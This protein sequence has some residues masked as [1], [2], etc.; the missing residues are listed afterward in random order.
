MRRLR[1]YPPCVVVDTP[2]TCHHGH[3]QLPIAPT[4]RTS[5]HHSPYTHPHSSSHP[6]YTPRSSRSTITYPCLRLPAA[7]QVIAAH[8]R[9][10]TLQLPALA[11]PPS[12][13]AAALLR[14]HAHASVT[15]STS[16][17]P[18]SAR[19]HRRASAADRDCSRRA[20]VTALLLSAR[21]RHQVLAIECACPAG[22]DRAI[23]WA[24]AR[25]PAATRRRGR[26][27][28][29]M[30]KQMCLSVSKPGR[31]WQGA[32]APGQDGPVASQRLSGV[33]GGRIARDAR[34]V[35]RSV[36]DWLEA[37]G[38]NWSKA[39][40]FYVIQSSKRLGRDYWIQRDAASRVM[41]T[42]G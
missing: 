34:G 20:R 5:V 4:R 2:N 9:S 17:I 27:L 39:C 19:R 42:T 12:T 38:R 22:R 3:S 13:F 26:K 1:C 24:A 31:A 36:D 11:A 37:G 40:D 25:R 21:A 8:R 35:L 23:T 30:R 41:Y 18:R 29:G 32:R 14:A 28:G 16:Q 10:R 6:T 7:Q 33:V 15:P